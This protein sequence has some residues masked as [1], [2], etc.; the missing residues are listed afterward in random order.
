LIKVTTYDAV[1]E[2]LRNAGFR[3][4]APIGIP[5]PGQGQQKLFAEKFRGALKYLGII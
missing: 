4:I 1:F 2:N 5:F 3:R